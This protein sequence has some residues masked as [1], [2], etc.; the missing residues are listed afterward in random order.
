MMNTLALLTSAF[1]AGVLTSASPCVLAAVPVT[2][3]FVGS[4]AQNRR[5]AIALSLT[6]VTGMTLAFAALG[7]AAARLGLFFGDLGGTWTMIVGAIVALVGL[8]LLFTSAD[9]CGLSMPS[10]VQERLKGSGLWGAGLLG[11]LTGT[12]M[13][14]CATPALAA[15]LSIAGTGGLWGNSAWIGAA[16]LLAY[17]LGHSVLLFAAGVAPSAV[18]TG[19]SRLE[20]QWGSAAIRYALA[21]LVV[22]SGVWI[23]ASSLSNW[24]L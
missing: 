15:A 23:V 3:G 18:Q 13:T 12:I 4:Q 7:L 22:A 5:E 19:L 11:T 9:R 8:W 2:I 17:G 10:G 20:T 14:P 1:I 16:M 24:S 6:F 21:G